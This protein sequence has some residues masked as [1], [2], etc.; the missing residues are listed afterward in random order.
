MFKFQ[1]NSQEHELHLRLWLLHPQRC[2]L[3]TMVM[4][5]IHLRLKIAFEYG[6]R[7][8][9]TSSDTFDYVM[10]NLLWSGLFPLK[11]LILMCCPVLDK[12][13]MMHLQ[14]SPGNFTGC[15]NVRHSCLTNAHLVLY[16]FTVV[17]YLFTLITSDE[18][19]MQ[20]YFRD[21]CE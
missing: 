11:V 16:V 5:R 8:P 10:S 15:G 17:A 2:R 9:F 4:W 12:H 1:C 18:C 13:H 6:G 14:L 3:Q 20:C 7:H 19:F 21:S